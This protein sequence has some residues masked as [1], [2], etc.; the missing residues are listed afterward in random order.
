[1]KRFIKEI[2]QNIK[3]CIHCKYFIRH[4]H[5]SPY[6]LIDHNEYGKCKL[7]GKISIIAGKTEYD[8]AKKFVKI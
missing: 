2:P 7:F 5:D 4:W 3:L 6:E 8:Y 1:M